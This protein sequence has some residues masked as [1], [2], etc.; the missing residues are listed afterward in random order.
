MIRFDAAP[1]APRLKAASLGAVAL[2]AVVA[3]TLWATLPQGATTPG[4]IA[5]FLVVVPP[6]AIA[7]ALL[8]VVR[9]YRIEGDRLEVQRLLWSTRI[10]LDGLERAW[11]DP[12]AMQRSI[13]V[14]GNGGLFA[15]SGL[16]RSRALGNYRA[17]VTRPDRA[18]VLRTPS[19]VV[20][21]S[22]AEPRAFLHALAAR[23]PHATFGEPRASG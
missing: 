20:V 7:A 8:F 22:P 15:I 18:V 6:I 13:R 19:R 12:Q 3:G 10:P 17:F 2:L 4:A 14:F 1:W 11:H 9:G 16:F 5:K 21:I 23:H